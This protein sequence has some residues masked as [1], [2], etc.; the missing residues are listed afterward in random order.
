MPVGK[1]FLAS[2]E[3]TKYWVDP[4]HEEPGGGETE[5]VDVE[6]TNWLCAPYLAAQLAGDPRAAVRL[7]VDDGL[8]RG[9][10]V[11]NLYLD[12]IQAAQHQIGELWQQNRITIAT[13]P[14]RY[15][16]LAGRACR[17]LSSPGARTRE[18]P[19]SA[20]GVRGRGIA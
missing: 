10:P 12:V 5:A 17:G 13:E 15:G 16:N 19:P 6:R 3:V 7:I 11:V 14:Y 8:G 18:W 9:I 20:C 2:P 4:A 1:T